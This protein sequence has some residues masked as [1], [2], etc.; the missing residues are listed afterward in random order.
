MHPSTQSLH[1]YVLPCP[2][3]LNFSVLLTW[4]EHCHKFTERFGWEGTSGGLYPNSLPTAGRWGPWGLAAPQR[5]GSREPALVRR[6][7]K[8][9]PQQGVD[10]VGPVMAA[11]FSRESRL[12]DKPVVT[13]QVQG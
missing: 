8:G 9:L 1:R 4:L 11:G 5:N 2:E 3:K 13:R 10:V 7:R 12:P 6:Q